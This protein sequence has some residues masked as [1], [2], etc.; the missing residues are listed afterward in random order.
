[1]EERPF[2]SGLR[3]QRKDVR[4]RDARFVVG[5]SISVTH[6]RGYFEGP[7]RRRKLHD[8]I[9][10]IP[11]TRLASQPCANQVRCEPVLGSQ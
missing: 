7:A 2:A 10:Y 11:R 1:M 9:R 3:G 6:Y 4:W 8:S 5:N